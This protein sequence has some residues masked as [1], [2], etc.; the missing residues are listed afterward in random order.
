MGR[1]RW[2]GHCGGAAGVPLSRVVSP[3]AAVGW[4]KMPVRSVVY[5]SR[6]IMAT[7]TAVM[8]SL[9]LGAECG[10]AED[11]VAVRGDEHL[12]EP[13]RLGQGPGSQD[14]GHRQGE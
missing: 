3:S 5:G 12:E 2:S 4:V 11:L 13:A 6:P 8:S 1:D 9:A 7:W 14:G 10:E